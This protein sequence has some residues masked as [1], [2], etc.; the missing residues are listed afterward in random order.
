[1]R[2]ANL[3][4][5]PHDA[6]MVILPKESPPMSHPLDVEVVKTKC[7]QG[8]GVAAR[9]GH[10]LKR[11]KNGKNREILVKKGE[12]NSENGCWLEESSRP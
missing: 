4:K 11:L 7:H 3:P 6:S 12:R 10:A 9:R 2:E 5:T 1:M 8:V